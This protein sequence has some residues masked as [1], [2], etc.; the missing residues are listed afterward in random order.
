MFFACLNN[1]LDVLKVFYM[2]FTC[3]KIFFIDIKNIIM[4]KTLQKSFKTKI[5]GENFF[6]HGKIIFLG[7]WKC[8]RPYSLDYKIFHWFKKNCNVKQ[9]LKSFKIGLNDDFFFAC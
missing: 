2:I 5:N 6:L 1:F 9:Q 7:F 4:L 3:Q 8:F